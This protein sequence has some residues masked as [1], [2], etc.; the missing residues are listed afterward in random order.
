MF[1]YL[2]PVASGSD[3]QFKKPSRPLPLPSPSSIPLYVWKF[4]A[5]NATMGKLFSGF[6]FWKIGF[7][8]V[9]A[10]SRDTVCSSSPKGKTDNFSGSCQ[11]YSIPCHNT[12]AALERH[13]YA[14]V[15]T[16]LITALN[17][18]FLQQPSE[19]NSF[20]YQCASCS[21]HLFKKPAHRIFSHDLSA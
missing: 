5:G 2:E 12:P 4:S 9:S 13:P 18:Y 1:T 3:T 7:Y 16:A 17:K 19:K 14:L 15:S 11:L 8:F 6:N 21:W 20:S 10:N